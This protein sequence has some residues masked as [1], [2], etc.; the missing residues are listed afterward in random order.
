MAHVL[1]LKDGSFHTLLTEQ[2]FYELV[3]E[4][5]GSE[6]R[7]YLLEIIED[8]AYLVQDQAEETYE[9]LEEKYEELKEK[10]ESLKHERSV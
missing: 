3:E 7:K 6:A 5:M 10:Y 4:T 2:D 1:K 9:E 8:T